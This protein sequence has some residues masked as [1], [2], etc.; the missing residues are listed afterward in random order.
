MGRILFLFQQLTS[1][2]RIVYEQRKES[3]IPAG[4]TRNRILDT[5]YSR[6]FSPESLVLPHLGD[7]LCCAG[8]ICGH[9]PR[10]D[11][12]QGAWF[13]QPGYLYLR[14]TVPSDWLANCQEPLGRVAAGAGHDGYCDICHLCHSPSFQFTL[15]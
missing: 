14:R 11:Y 1:T 4:D 2:L 13:P 12:A 10:R 15:P 3:P 6:I 5:G 8:H 7:Y 9:N